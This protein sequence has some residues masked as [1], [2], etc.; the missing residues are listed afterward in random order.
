MSGKPARPVKGADMGMGTDRRVNKRA[1]VRGKRM[2]RLLAGTVLVVGLVG[3]G[4]S[5][6]SAG[7][8][9]L[10]ASCNS[11]PYRAPHVFIDSED[12]VPVGGRTIQRVATREW[13]YHFESGQWTSGPWNIYTAT[14]DWIV[15]IGGGPDFYLGTGYYAAYVEAY[16]WDG[17]AWQGPTTST[18]VPFQDGSYWCRGR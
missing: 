5:P 6:A 15:T 3:V 18:F 16:A 9:T 7:R 8:G 17:S 4:S 2:A 10:T 11:D 13:L 1:A 12:L 14:F